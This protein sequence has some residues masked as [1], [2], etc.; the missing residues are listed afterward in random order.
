MRNKTLFKLYDQVNSVLGF[1]NVDCV[2]RKCNFCENNIG[3]AFLFPLEDEYLNEKIG[4]VTPS[5][6]VAYNDIT[7]KMLGISESGRCGFFKDGKCIIQKLKPIECKLYPLIVRES[8]NHVNLELDVRC[9]EALKLQ[10][11]KKYLNLI[12]PPLKKLINFLPKEY[13]IARREL[14]DEMGPNVKTIKIASL[15]KV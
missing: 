11:D 14:P 4:V 7:V 2:R 15:R 10:K 3:H 13:F 1:A 5:E 9:P 8:G 6:K 12:L